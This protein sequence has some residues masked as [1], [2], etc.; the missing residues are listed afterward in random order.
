M[1]SRHEAKGDQAA[2]TRRYGLILAA[3]GIVGLLAWYGRVLAIDHKLLGPLWGHWAGGRALPFWLLRLG[4]PPVTVLLGVVALLAARR[5]RAPAP[6]FFAVAL[7]LFV[8]LA[9]K[10]FPLWTTLVPNYLL[11]AFYVASG[12]LVVRWT[13]TGRV[14]QAPKG[15]HREP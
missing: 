5:W 9:A 8:P 10:G 13:S 2:W 11:A 3:V 1:R 7:F 15:E 6:W 14:S 12:F 4:L